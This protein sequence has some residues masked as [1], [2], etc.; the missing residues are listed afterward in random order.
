MKINSF[1]NITSLL[2]NGYLLLN[3][4]VA[5][6]DA[7]YKASRSWDAFCE[8]PEEIKRAIGYSNGAAGVGC[9]IKKGEGAAADFKINFDIALIGESWLRE[10][11][12][13]INN[14][15][16]TEFV[17]D[18][19]ALVAAVT[20][21]I[22]H[23]AEESERAFGLKGFGHEVKDNPDT[24]FI[25]FIQYV[26]NPKI[27][28]EICVPH[29]DQSGFTLHL[30]ESEPGFQILSAAGKWI[31]IPITCGQTVIIPSMQ[32]QLRSEGML[33]ATCHRVIAKSHVGEKPYRTSAV[34]FGQLAHTP[35][36]DKARYGRLQE[37]A[38]GFNYDMPFSDFEKMFK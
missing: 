33:K 19:L 31:D 37:M 8:L 15:I 13:A 6:Y 11:I 10:R 16:V 4:P 23:F 22:A 2:T 1:S 7:V 14:P 21:T 34:L 25:R 24:F 35:K 30:R 9:E 20:P 17:N 26:A 29:V 12:V 38:P 5:L 28:D 36:Y 27:G 18:A 3:Y 32:M